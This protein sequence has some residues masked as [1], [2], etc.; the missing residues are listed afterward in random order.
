[1]ELSFS[2]NFATFLEPNQERASRLEV[3][4]GQTGRR[5]WPDDVK[6][7]IVAE[8]LA[9]GAR[10]CEV[11]QRHWVAPQY[12]TAW[13]RLARGGR[14]GLPVGEGCAFASVMVGDVTEVR[15]VSTAPAH[16]AIEIEV[17]GVVVLLPWNISAARIGEIAA[18]LRRRARVPP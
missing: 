16:T 10:V 11:A 18:A 1:M 13:R 4:E 9:P 17:G 2:Q 8:S 12:L 14:L 3:L 7:R 15:T 6:A 5:K